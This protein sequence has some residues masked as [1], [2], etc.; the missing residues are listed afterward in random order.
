MVIGGSRTMVGNSLGDNINYGLV[1]FFD[2][3]R[4]KLISSNRGMNTSDKKSI[5]GI[6]VADT[7]KTIL[8]KENQ[9]NGAGGVELGR[10]I[11]KG[12]RWIKDVTTKM[13]LEL[14]KFVGSKEFD[15]AKFALIVK[16]KVRL[17]GRNG[18]R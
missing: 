15:P 9:F 10:K 14:M 17:L 6:D 8:I 2:L 16:I 5:I 12:K 7:G 11:I 3:K 4:L 13:C 18:S 1:K